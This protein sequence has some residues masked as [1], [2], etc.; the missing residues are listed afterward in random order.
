MPKTLLNVEKKIKI[1]SVTK[2]YDIIVF[3]PNGKIFLIV[4]CKAMH[5][6]ISQEVFDQIARY[7]LVLNADYLM[8]SNGLNNYYCQMDFQKECYVFL[9]DLPDYSF[10]KV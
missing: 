6:P 10:K 1:G 7:N 5:I 8:V 2:R 3:Y 4:E 9:R